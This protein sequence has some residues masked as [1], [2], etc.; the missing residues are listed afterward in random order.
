MNESVLLFW[1]KWWQRLS[2][3]SKY[4]FLPTKDRINTLC[5]L[6]LTYI[7]DLKYVRKP[8]DPTANSARSLWKPKN[9]TKCT[10][11]QLPDHSAH[12]HI[13]AVDKAQPWL[14]PLSLETNTHVAADFEIRSAANTETLCRSLST[15]S[16]LPLSLLPLPYRF[17]R[18]YQTLLQI[19]TRRIFIVSFC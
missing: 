4:F 10:C 1:V 12:T 19:H 2:E 17:Y 18:P 3:L 15:K 13:N 14:S 7:N 9:S 16:L 8:F 5:M 11:I 6:K